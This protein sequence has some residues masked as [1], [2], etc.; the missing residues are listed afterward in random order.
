MCRMPPY[1]LMDV[2]HL[3]GK[4]PVCHAVELKLEDDKSTETDQ[5]LSLPC[6][7]RLSN[8]GLQETE[9]VAEVESELLREFG[10]LGDVTLPRVKDLCH[11]GL[12]EEGRGEVG[13]EG[14]RG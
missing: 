6:L 10:V 8:P 2:P 13:R 1:L 5:F 11:T 14:V 12:Q 7:I 4:L 3:L 9:D